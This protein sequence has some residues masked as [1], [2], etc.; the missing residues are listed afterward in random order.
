[1][2]TDIVNELR[3]LGFGTSQKTNIG[4]VVQEAASEIQRLRREVAK[5]EKRVSDL[6]WEISPDRMGR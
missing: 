3:A 6:G 1:M 2:T 4:P 5:L